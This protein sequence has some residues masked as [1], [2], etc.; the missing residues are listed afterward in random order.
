MRSPVSL[1][2]PLEHPAPDLDAVSQKLLDNDEILH[3]KCLDAGSQSSA[4]SPKTPP[5]PNPLDPVEY[6]RVWSQFKAQKLRSVDTTCN[7]R[8]LI[9]DYEYWRTESEFLAFKIT[10][11]EKRR[12]QIQDTDYWKIESRHWHTAWRTKNDEAHRRDINSL[13]YWR[14]EAA[15]WNR[16][17]AS[18]R[19]EVD[20][21]NYW[22]TEHDHYA[23]KLNSLVADVLRSPHPAAPTGAHRIRGTSATPVSHPSCIFSSSSTRVWQPTSIAT[24]SYRNGKRSRS[25]MECTP[26]DSASKRHKLTDN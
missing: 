15:F 18:F 21:A 23:S 10:N 24:Q 3:L 13:A 5:Y 14:C 20:D 4:E 25:R 12:Q 9:A 26:G 17:L 6:W 7:H 1:S 11:S 19:E 22:K 2:C 16:T 8:A